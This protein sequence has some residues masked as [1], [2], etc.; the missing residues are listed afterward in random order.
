MVYCEYLITVSI[1][2]KILKSNRKSNIHKIFLKNKIIKKQPS[3]SF[4]RYIKREMKICIQ[5]KIFTLIIITALFIITKTVQFSRGRIPGSYDDSMFNIS[6]DCSTVY[7]SGC[8]ICA[9]LDKLC[10]SSNF[11]TPSPNFL[12]C[13]LIFWL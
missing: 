3:G 7:S 13:V 6:K 9:F 10:M 11:F 5:T 4:P 2:V 8:T 12:L 1:T